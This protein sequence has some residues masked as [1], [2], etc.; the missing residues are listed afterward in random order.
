MAKKRKSKDQKKQDASDI[1][2][3]I[4]ESTPQP[5][6]EIQNLIQA[7]EVKDI[8][9]RLKSEESESVNP[10]IVES[11]SFLEGDATHTVE[12]K[13]IAESKHKIATKESKEYV[14]TG[15][16]FGDIGVFLTELTN[17]YGR[18]YDSWEE[19]TII[20]DKRPSSMM[21]R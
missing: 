9:P 13:L 1:Q 10:N 2:P 3:E 18:R 12:T 5:R 20:A 11:P 15:N 16:L 21:G 6:A 14:C 4:D 19:S 8:V 7:L 17:S